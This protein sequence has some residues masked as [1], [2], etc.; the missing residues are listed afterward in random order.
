MQYE[1]TAPPYEKTVPS[2]KQHKYQNKVHVVKAFFLMTFWARVIVVLSILVT[3]SALN[4][5]FPISIFPYPVP[6]IETLLYITSKMWAIV[7]ALWEL[8]YSFFI[9]FSSDKSI[10]IWILLVLVIVSSIIQYRYAH[11]RFAEIKLSEI[12]NEDFKDSLK[13]SE[14]YINSH[15]KIFSVSLEASPKKSREY[16]IY[17]PKINKRLREKLIPVK[18]RGG[19]IH[20]FRLA[21][22]LRKL[23]PIVLSKRLKE[24]KKF[25]NERL[26][27]MEE[28]LYLETF[29][30]KSFRNPLALRRTSYFD[31]QCS[32]E[33]IFRKFIDRV[34]LK[35]DSTVDGKYLITN[36]DFVVLPYEESKC[37]NFLGASTLVITKDKQIL[38]TRQS[39]TNMA[40]PGKLAPSGSG[41][42]SWKKEKKAATLQDL[43]AR[44]MEREFFEEWLILKSALEA[45]IR[46]STQVIGYA[47]LI[48]R[49]GKPDF[50]GISYVNLTKKR[51]YENFYLQ[52]EKYLEVIPATDDVLGNCSLSART[53]KDLRENLSKFIE[54]KQKTGDLSIQLYLMNLFLNELTESEL[55]DILDTLYE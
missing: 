23:V 11:Y 55:Q 6:I 18:R 10:I 42:V 35:K 27:R 52:R 26:I 17:S 53:A 50:F 19:I 12:E 25:V 38:I 51:L 31:G 8:V 43:V 37:A 30:E 14:N 44:A 22:E 7:N 34:S 39:Q 40:N 33:L 54:M 20:K 5:L 15:Y 9:L 46:I 47:R 45:D 36:D 13:L 16:C 4:S 21:T 3:L 1:K 29:S 41:S 49:G 24:P 48:E 2:T 32:N 28:S